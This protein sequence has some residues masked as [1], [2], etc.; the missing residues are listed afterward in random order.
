MCKADGVGSHLQDQVDILL[1]ILVGQSI[2]DLRSVLM[3][4]H[5][6]Q[7]ITLTI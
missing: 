2:T 1:M 4:G 5:A 6:V 3:T 7:R